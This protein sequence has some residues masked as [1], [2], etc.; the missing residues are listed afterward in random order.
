M[1]PELLGNIFALAS[2]CDPLSLVQEIYDLE[3]KN[4][5]F[6]CHPW[7]EVVIDSA[8]FWTHIDEDMGLLWVEAFFVR[9]GNTSLSYTSYFALRRNLQRSHATAR[10]IMSQCLVLSLHINNTDQTLDHLLYAPGP[11][12]KS[13]TIVKHDLCLPHLDVSRPMW[14]DINTSLSSGITSLSISWDKDVDSSWIPDI[15]S[16]SKF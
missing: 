7:R 5:T 15:S 6:V 8:T 4:L 3:R 11:R 9:S 16:I 14:L 2:T 10:D 13:V 1:P 12:L